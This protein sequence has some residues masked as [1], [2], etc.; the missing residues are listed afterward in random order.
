MPDLEMPNADARENGDR[1]ILSLGKITLVEQNPAFSQLKVQ[2]VVFSKN[3]SMIQTIQAGKHTAQ[4]FT[5][6]LRANRHRGF[7][8][9]FVNSK[10]SWQFAHVS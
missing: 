5:A 4:L 7:L 10:Y 8:R 1:P 6:Q 3:P 9:N 2:L